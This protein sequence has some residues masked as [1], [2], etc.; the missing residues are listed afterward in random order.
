[1]KIRVNRL[2]LSETLSLVGSVVPSRTP[3]PV[4]RGV[5]MYTQGDTLR[6]YGTDLELSIDAGLSQV[7]IERQGRVLL[8]ADRIVGI[9]R[10]GGDEVLDFDVAGDA[11]TIVGSDSR[12]KVYTLDIEQYPIVVPASKA[13]GLSVS[14]KDMREAARQVVFA[15]AKESSRYAING[16][17]F[18]LKGKRLGLVATDGRRLARRRVNGTV[19]EGCQLAAQRV[20][21]PTKALA[22]VERLGEDGE[23]LSMDL[24]GNQIVISCGD[25]AICS[26]LVEGTFP[27]YEDIIPSDYQRRLELDTL[28]FSSAI[29]RAALLTTDQAKGIKISITSDKMVLSS[30]AP[31]A[32][33]AEV[34]MPI[35][36]GCQ[37]L[38][39]GF[40]PQYLLEALRVVQAP[41][42]QLELG[43]ADRPAI[44]KA[45]PDFLY[46]VMPINLG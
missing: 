24:S 4:L 37:P 46:L 29:K 31:E 19:S 17:L 13:G 2:A 14:L 11:C 7:E 23:E 22:L 26:N 40:N 12:Y 43:E 20:I 10:E 8:D 34:T 27:K 44:I 45:E 41:R 28:A 30:R 3:K 6:L 35:S 15:A 36:A 39:I 1:M 16:V 42:I 32:G 18:E 25:V 33:D 21:V 9:V 38:D 5:L